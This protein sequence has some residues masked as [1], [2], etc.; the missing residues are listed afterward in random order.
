MAKA[1]ANDAK[2]WGSSAKVVAWA[3]ATDWKMRRNEIEV[4][5][6]RQRNGLV[7]YRVGSEKPCRLQGWVQYER[8]NGRSWSSWKTERQTAVRIQACR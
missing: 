5:T 7:L 2:D 8:G 6:G 1:V 3:G 4:I